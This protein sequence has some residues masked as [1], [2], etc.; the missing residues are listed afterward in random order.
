MGVSSHPHANVNFVRAGTI[1]TWDARV[2]KVI[3][4]LDHRVLRG[5]T[6]EYE[7]EW[8]GQ[9]LDGIPRPLEWKGADEL[10][11]TS[12]TLTPRSGHTAW[13]PS[14]SRTTSRSAR[15]RGGPAQ[16]G[17]AT[18]DPSLACTRRRAV[19]C[20]RGGVQRL[21]VRGAAA[22]SCVCGRHARAARLLYTFAAEWCS[23]VVGTLL[24]AQLGEGIVC[25]FHV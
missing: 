4:I 6:V 10:T 9:K 7:I 19:A 1:D 14:W 15:L 18:F 5:G 17:R 2:F 20:D 16:D 11:P 13:L 22:L 24:A 8:D 25:A 12:S 21:S 23:Q 3:R